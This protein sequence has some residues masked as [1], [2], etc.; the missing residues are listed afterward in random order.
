MVDV[1]HVGRLGDLLD[2]VARLLLGADEQH[3]ATAMGDLGCHF[4]CL[5]QKH[6]CL[7]QVD[8]VDAVALTMDEA[9]H[10]GVPAACLMAEMN[11]GLQQVRDSNLTHGCSLILILL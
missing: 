1:G 6:C 9:A 7:Q 2:R 11:S 3:G 10:L 5:L 8:D 4:L